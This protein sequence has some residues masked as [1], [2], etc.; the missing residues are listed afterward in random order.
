[1]L[2]Q[3][4][5]AT[6]K[7]LSTLPFFYSSNIRAAAG[8]ASLNV[9]GVWR[10]FE[11]QALKEIAKGKFSLKR[12]K[13][14]GVWHVWTLIENQNFVFLFVKSTRGGKSGYHIIYEPW[15]K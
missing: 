12:G 8:D 10:A 2:I 15:H 7:H 14:F 6:A 13:A 1:M 5:L 9:C 3:G 11:V 4:D